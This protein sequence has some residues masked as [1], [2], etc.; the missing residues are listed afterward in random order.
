[1]GHADWIDD[2]ADTSR[3]GLQKAQS[4]ARR[5]LDHLAD[6]VSEARDAMAPVLRNMRS[7]VSQVRERTVDYVRDEPV[8][9]ALVAAAVGTLV[10]AL[11][12]MLS[13]RSNSR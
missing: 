2:A 13:S 1:M 12:H 6:G 11:W 5:G 4:A 9:S 10:F 3:L 7:G 8:R